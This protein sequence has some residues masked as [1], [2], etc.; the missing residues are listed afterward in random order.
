MSDRVKLTKKQVNQFERLSIFGELRGLPPT[1][2]KIIALL[3]ISPEIELTFDQIMN[4]LNISKSTTSTSLTQ[5][6]NL[7]QVEYCTK[8]G[9]RKR[10]FRITT[11]DLDFYFV[12]Y[13]QRLTD[14][15][16]LYKEILATRPEETVQ[17]NNSLKTRIKV[18][19]IVAKA[20]Q[21]SVTA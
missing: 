9:E 18:L 5:L 2:A 8:I 15:A 13:V 16:D 12:E 1:S 11:R 14:T 17:F 10:F 6:Q 19:Q 4:T 3:T 21:S 7:K 20:L